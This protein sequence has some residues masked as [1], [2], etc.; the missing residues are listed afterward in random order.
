M[1]QATIVSQIHQARLMVIPIREKSSRLRT[2]SN[3]LNMITIYV[4]TRK[5]SVMDVSHRPYGRLVH[6]ANLEFRV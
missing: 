1:E 4:T 6:D 5:N 3:N 2:P